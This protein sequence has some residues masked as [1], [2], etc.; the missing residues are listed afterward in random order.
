MQ[1]FNPN[2]FEIGLP[3]YLGNA[4][5]GSINGPNLVDVD[6]S[7]MKSTSLPKLGEAAGIWS[8]ADDFFNVLNHTNFG[9]P[10]NTIFNGTAGAVTANAAAGRIST[11]IGTARQLQFS[12]RFVF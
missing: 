3:G 8:S 5:R 12:A 9:L 11:I 2:A 10:N 7:V 6:F 1:W 4:P